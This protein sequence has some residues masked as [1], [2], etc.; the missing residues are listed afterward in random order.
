MR[1]DLEQRLRELLDE[2]Q[3]AAVLELLERERLHDPLT[4][5]PNRVLLLD[6]TATALARLRRGSWRVA[7]MHV[8]IDRLSVINETLGLRAGDELLKALGPRLHGVLRPGDTVARSTGDGFGILCEGIAD[9]SHAVRI[10][11]R[12][13]DAFAEPFELA[14]GKHYVSASVG[15]AVAATGHE[16]D[17]L[18]ANAETA[19]W[20][21]R[22]RGRGHQELHDAAQRA[23]VATRLRLERDLRDALACDNQLWVAYQPIHEAGGGV[24]AVE[25][26]ARWTHPAQGN[27]PP[28]DFIAIAEDSGLIVALGEHILREACEQAAHWG[29]LSV[30]VNVSA[31]Q[32]TA[33]GLVDSVTR[34]LDDTGLAPDRLW[35]ELTEGL[36]LDDSA[37]VH[38]TLGE[39]AGMGVRLVLDDFGTGYSSLAYL[40]RFPLEMLKIDRSFIDDAPIVAAIV[41]MARALGMRTVPEGVET[42]EQLERVIGLD[43]DYVQG[44][45]LSR[46]MA[47]RELEAQL[48]S[49]R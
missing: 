9:E 3:L 19:M 23:R 40:R 12:V 2:Q 5:L 46:P 24:A 26:L 31:R 13:A 35:L 8:G 38:A 30:S 39:L 48:A 33:P 7:L 14:G 29:G 25:A 27:V 20:R 21:A 34:T 1:G 49:P 32:V 47:A 6:R 44:Y 18:I 10:A 42:A 36:L 43:C 15:I 22:E 11:Q 28:A 17:V 16:P 37:T 4:G 45:H 41:G